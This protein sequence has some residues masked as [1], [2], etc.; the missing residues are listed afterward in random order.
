MRFQLCLNQQLLTGTHKEQSVGAATPFEP[1]IQ[2]EPHTRTVLTW[3]QAH[4]GRCRDAQGRSAAVSIYQGTEAE[5][6]LPRHWA[7]DR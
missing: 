2:G 3:R 6:D 1:T 7:I 4:R 5:T